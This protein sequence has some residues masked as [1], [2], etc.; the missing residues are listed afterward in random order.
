MNRNE[1]YDKLNQYK[2]NSLQHYGIQGQKKGIRRW[3]NPD[4]TFNEEGK[5]RYFGSKKLNEHKVNRKETYYN[6]RSEEDKRARNWELTKAGIKAGLTGLAYAA[7]EGGVI[8]V[9]SAFGLGTMTIPVVGGIL[10]AKNLVKAGYNHIDSK[11][12]EKKANQYYDLLKE[13]Q[14]EQI[15]KEEE[16][17]NE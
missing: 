6:N 16:N 9:L 7:T 1:F 17:Q 8:P 3:Q 12:C 10:I 11:Y 5:L 4:G 2:S 14:A 13:N 15:K